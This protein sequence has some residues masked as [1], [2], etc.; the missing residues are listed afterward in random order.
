MIE[1]Q[2]RTKSVEKVE[3]KLFRILIESQ[4]NSMVNGSTEANFFSNSPNH[5]H[6][7]VFL[8]WEG[9]L[10]SLCTA[11]SIA[12]WYSIRQNVWISE[13]L[14]RKRQ[15]K[16]CITLDLDHRAVCEIN[17]ILVL[18][19]ECACET[20]TLICCIASLC[21]SQWMFFSSRSF[22]LLIE[23]TLVLFTA[24]SVGDFSVP[25]FALTVW[26]NTNFKMAD[27]YCD[28]SHFVLS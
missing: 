21:T 6:L 26:A 24:N 9:K 15:A 20:H 14:Q 28:R 23:A 12:S 27:C 10:K 13:I 3:F 4:C 5:F 2:K 11:H 16:L 1:N 22:L 19:C 17:K 18:D 25:H 7:L 8:Y